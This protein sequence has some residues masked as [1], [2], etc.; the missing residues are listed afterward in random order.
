MKKG[1]PIELLHDV[2]RQRIIKKGDVDGTTAGQH[3]VR[4]HS[5]VSGT[6]YISLYDF[7]PVNNVQEL[8]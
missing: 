3:Y 1:Q 8:N 2:H 4:L 6:I 7:L 5:P